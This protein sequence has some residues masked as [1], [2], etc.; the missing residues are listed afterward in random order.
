MDSVEIRVHGIGDH[1]PLSALGRGALLP[2]PGDHSDVETYKLPD[3]P[4]DRDLRFVNWSR[5]SRRRIRMV[6]Y[7]ALPFTLINVAGHM[8]PPMRV[9]PAMRAL[10]WGGVVVMGVVLSVA[11]EAWLIRAPALV[12]RANET[13]RYAKRY[14]V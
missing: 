7:L 1:G 12:Q 8:R 9:A 3:I 5:T 6:W 4:A 13:S 11:A 2:A 10:H 14:P